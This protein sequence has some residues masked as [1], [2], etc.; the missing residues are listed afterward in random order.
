MVQFE[1][2]SLKPDNSLSL[3]NEQYLECRWGKQGPPAM[4]KATIEN[5]TT[6]KLNQ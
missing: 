6:I 2:K 5:K 3:I 1:L 4:L